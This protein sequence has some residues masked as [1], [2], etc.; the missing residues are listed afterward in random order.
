MPKVLWLGR[1]EPGLTLSLRPTAL[2]PWHRLPQR[3]CG[4]GLWRR[5]KRDAVRLP[6][7]SDPSVRGQRG[8][9]WWHL[10]L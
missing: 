6:K 2:G 4:R 5:E 8:V 1:G 9:C 10:W 7:G 3:L